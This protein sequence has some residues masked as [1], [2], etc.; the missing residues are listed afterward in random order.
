MTSNPAML[1][2]E[3]A[4]KLLRQFICIERIPSERLPNQ[5]TIRQAVMLVRDHSDYQILGICADTAE[6]AIATL[7]AYLTA[8]GFSDLPQPSPIEGVVYLKFNPKTGLCYLEPY[9]GNHR[10]V[11]VS[12]QSAYDGDVNET[13]GHLPLDLFN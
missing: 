7:H 3:S 1:T 10:G 12:C 9:D 2:L 4:Q 13:F 11:L 6:Q 8:F 5:A